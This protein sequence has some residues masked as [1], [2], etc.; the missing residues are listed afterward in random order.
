[1]AGKGGFLNEAV[2][3]ERVVDSVDRLDG[4]ALSGLVRKAVGEEHEP[5][6][7]LNRGL[8]IGLCTLGQGFEC[9]PGG[10]W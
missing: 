4:G 3:I 5:A 10:Q 1:M 8:T 6:A 9:I 2:P 7:V